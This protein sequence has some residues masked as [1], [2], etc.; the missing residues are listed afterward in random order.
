[1]TWLQYWAELPG[2]SD[3]EAYMAHLTNYV[4]EQKK[5]GRF[6]RPVNNAIHDVMAWMRYNEVVVDEVKVLISLG[7]LFFVVCLLSCV[8]LLLTKVNGHRSELS[9]RR[10][11]G[12]SRSQV[13]LQNLIECR[14]RGWPA[15]HRSGASGADGHPGRYLS[16]PGPHVPDR[17]GDCGSLDCD[18]GLGH[19]DCGPVPRLEGMRD[20]TRERT[21]S[22]IGVDPWKSAPSSP[23]CVT[24]R[25]ARFSSR[26]RSRSA[27]R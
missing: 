23:R 3:R 9:L 12:A 11:L 25:R 24:T 26:C 27:L 15:R 13:L 18:L 19:G 1:M 4:N 22:P 17:L 5:L 8:S 14:R 6:E 21:E 20:R 2:A 16:G 7:F 10:A